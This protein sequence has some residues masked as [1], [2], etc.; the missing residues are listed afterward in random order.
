[1]TSV[2]GNA[3]GVVQMRYIYLINSTHS[4]KRLDSLLVPYLRA[5]V[6]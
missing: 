1:M 2:V 4:A 5:S 6:G 3:L